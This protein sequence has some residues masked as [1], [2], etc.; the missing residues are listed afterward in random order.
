VC[1]VS[2]K[3]SYESGDG[4]C[5]AIDRG[6]RRLNSP[7]YFILVCIVVAELFVLWLLIVLLLR[8]I[9]DD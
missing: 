9:D 1:S 8:M 6:A 3:L 5:G 7:P 2:V 4:V